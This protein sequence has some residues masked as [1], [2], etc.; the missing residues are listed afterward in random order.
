MTPYLARLFELMDA[1]DEALDTD[2]FEQASAQH[3]DAPDDGE[4]AV[5]FGTVRKINAVFAEIEAIRKAV[6]V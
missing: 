3:F 4:C 1:A 2:A 6:G 5:T